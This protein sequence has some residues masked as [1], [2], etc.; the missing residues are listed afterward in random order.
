MYCF[1]VKATSAL[2]LF[3]VCNFTFGICGT[4]LIRLSLVIQYNYLFVQ[5][6]WTCVVS[7]PISS[8]IKNSGRKRTLAKIRK[9]RNYN[10]EIT[11]KVFEKTDWSFL[12]CISAYS[13]R[14]DII[15]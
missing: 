14:G 8:S 11:Q 4:S 2:I 9:F 6:L 7:H 1:I 13:S 12:K 10:D 15:P 5:M 3:H